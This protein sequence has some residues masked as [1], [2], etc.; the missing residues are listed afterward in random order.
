MIEPGASRPIDARL[1]RSTVTLTRISSPTQAGARGA[2]L[3]G[4]ESIHDSG[5]WPGHSLARLPVIS[6][7][8]PCLLCRAL[9]WPVDRPTA[10]A[11][12][13]NSFVPSNSALGT[14]HKRRVMLQ[15]R[16]SGVPSGDDAVR[17][18]DDQR[19]ETG[20]RESEE[21]SRLPPDLASGYQ[22]YRRR[23]R[24]RKS[25]GRTCRGSAIDR[26]KSGSR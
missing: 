1:E 10:S 16:S 7:E 25:S 6:L 19:R 9:A 22:P 4:R 24:P 17:E 18:R 20:R 5:T 21:T 12:K 11:R 13:L 3:E 15:S 23:E 26:G 14:L 8:N 2:P